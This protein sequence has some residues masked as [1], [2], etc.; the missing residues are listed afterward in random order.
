MDYFILD[1]VFVADMTALIMIMFWEGIASSLILYAS[2]KQIKSL[3]NEPLSRK[4]IIFHLIRSVG[5][6]L[7]LYRGI[8]P[9]ALSSTT[10]NALLFF[11][12]YLDA[13]IIL[14]A[15]KLNTNGLKIYG[16]IVFVISSIVYVLMDVVLGLPN[17]RIVCASVSIFLT[18]APTVIKC[19]FGKHSNSLYRSFL[20]PYL[21]LI[22]LTIFRTIKAITNI[23]YALLE[24]DFLQSAFHSILIVKAFFSTLFLLV[25]LL[26]KSSDEIDRAALDPLTGVLGRKAYLIESKKILC[27]RCTNKGYLAVFFL[28]IDNFKRVNDNWGHDIGDKVI[29]AVATAVQRSINVEDVCCRYGGDEFSI[30]LLLD[31]PNLINTIAK[32]IKERL[33]KIDILEESITCSIGA[34]WGV[35]KEDTGIEDYIKKADEAMYLSKQNGRDQLTVLEIGKKNADMLIDI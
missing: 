13:Q 3:Q 33:C 23:D 7:F 29:V 11:A 21:L 34:A 27:E 25:I 10:A 35:P 22:I 32:R 15:T 14:Q 12:F 17:I 31:N 16:I 5:Y 8:F 6:F 9:D 1:K 20:W 24:T 19:M 4:S 28:D 18:F 26:S 2:R 30:C